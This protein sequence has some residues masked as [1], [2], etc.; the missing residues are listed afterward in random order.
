[1]TTNSPM[2]CLGNSG[3]PSPGDIEFNRPCRPTLL[4]STLTKQLSRIAE[5]AEQAMDPAAPAIEG[6]AGSTA[7]VH[8]WPH[9]VPKS[10]M[11]V[12]ERSDSGTAPL[13]TMID[14]DTVFHP[15]LPYTEQLSP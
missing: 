3:M 10:R 15:D 8:L 11:Q 14:S 2:Y 9:L 6:P 4:P 7:P 5:G 1:M 13:V 12:L